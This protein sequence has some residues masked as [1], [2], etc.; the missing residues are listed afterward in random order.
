MEE[1]NI[2][3]ILSLYRKQVRKNMIKAS[4]LNFSLAKSVRVWINAF[5]QSFPLETCIS[6]SPQGSLMFALKFVPSGGNK[7]DL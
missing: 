4:F 1:I 3:L 7:I 2:N 5:L 6:L